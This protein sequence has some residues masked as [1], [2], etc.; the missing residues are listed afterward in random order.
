MVEHLYPDETARR[1]ARIAR[2]L[3]LLEQ[4]HRFNASAEEVLRGVDDLT[5]AEAFALGREFERTRE[6]AHAARAAFLVRWAKV[7]R[8]LDS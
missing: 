7:R 5:P 8:K 2:C 4:V 6:D 3:P 1:R